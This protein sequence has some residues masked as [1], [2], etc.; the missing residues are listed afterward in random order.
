MLYQNFSKTPVLA[1]AATSLLL[2]LLLSSTAHAEAPMA[3]NEA[4]EVVISASRIEM[5]RESSGSAITVLDSDYLEQNQVQ[6]VSDVLR[7]VP[8]VAVSRT[9][10]A[11]APTQ[12]RIRG[13]EANQTLV[14]IDGIEVN[15]VASGSEFNFAHLMNLEVERIEVLRGAQSALWGSDAMGGVINI[16]TKRGKGSL[17]GKITVEGGSYD[18]H[19]ETLA[20]NAG[21]DDYHYALSGTLLNTNGI[22]AASEERGNREKDGYKNAT[23]NLKSGIDLLD[24]LSM[25]LVVRH[26]KSDVDTDSFLGGVGAVDSDD[27]T[28]TE[29]TSGKVSAKLDLLDEQWHHRLSFSAN[30]TDNTFFTA[31]TESYNSQGYKQKY[32]YQTDLFLY[33]SLTNSD[34]LEHR[35]TFAA[36]HEEEEFYNK[37]F[38]TIDRD[39]DVSGYVVEYG[40]NIDDRYYA[41]VAGR[42]DI[43][44]LFQNANTY[45][46]TFAGWVTDSVRLHTSK[47]KGIKNPTLFEL[48]GSTPDYTGN[49][50]LRPEENSTW[51]VGTEYHF[52][53]LDGYV[54]LTYFHTDVTNL[55][56]GSGQTSV[57]MPSDAKIKGV[58]LSLVLRPSDNTRL[59]S[60]YTYTDS[61]DGNGNE[62]VRRPEHVASI[63]G[64]YLFS[65]DQTRLTTG[66]QYNGKQDD[67]EY[68][69]N[70]NTSTVTLS[71]YTLVNVAL[72]HQLNKHIELFG[73][74]D[75][76]LNEE[77][78]EVLT[79]GT[80]GINGM[81]GITI[82]GSL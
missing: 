25:D 62:L 74:V 3:A 29:Q 78:E 20:I 55:I 17:N 65:N 41:T 28:E 79:Y 70:W 67:I 18:T 80:K 35:F 63:N 15:D 1:A 4:T 7:D 72:T 44:S 34:D 32:E 49:A 36:E 76:L 14:L 10:G 66:V 19:Q 58:E 60:S 46:L 16:V 45:R 11:G 6:V 51:D 40:A 37:G 59:N 81:V 8:G 43:N 38:S 73:R 24:N 57:N 68:D 9:G 2:L 77:Y 53:A 13:A 64:S 50:D 21:T 71:D 54:D 23:I 22:S 69:A 52:N 5:A 42:R 26:V 48:F 31:G 33:S 56:T 12:V 30:D 27:N 75:N 39:M 82:T 47:G 61:N